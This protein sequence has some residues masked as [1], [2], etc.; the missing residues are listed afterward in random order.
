MLC[1]AIY[2]TMGRSIPI[3][4]ALDAVGDGLRLAVSGERVAGYTMGLKAMLDEP[5]ALMAAVRLL[6]ERLEVGDER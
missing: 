6:L 1:E 3:E 2:A 4:R 5:D